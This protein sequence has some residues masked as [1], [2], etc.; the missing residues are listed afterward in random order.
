MA[1]LIK[2]LPDRTTLCGIC[3]RRRFI[4]EIWLHTKKPGLAP[5]CKYK[6]PQLRVWRNKESNSVHYSCGAYLSETEAYTSVKVGTADGSIPLQ[7][8]KDPASKP[9]TDLNEKR[10][11]K[12]ERKRKRMRAY[13]AER[14]PV[15][16][17]KE[18]IGLD[19]H[20]FQPGDPISEN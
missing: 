5:D 16:Y 3:L 12:E 20:L 1:Q 15:I 7:R 2:F 9:I 6:T 8:Y 17:M 11:K 14:E 19:E 4:D 13:W 10:T 18:G